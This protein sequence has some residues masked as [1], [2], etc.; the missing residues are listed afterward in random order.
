MVNSRWV[1]LPHLLQ[2]RAAAA[3]AVV[4]DRLVVTGGVD[5]SGALLNTTEVF[6][7]N[8]WSLGAPIPTPRQMLAAA[9]DGKLVYA[10][11]GTNGDRT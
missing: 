11:G 7:G 4:G 6:D 9:S 10:V 5:A 2:P 3:A 8:S 1:E